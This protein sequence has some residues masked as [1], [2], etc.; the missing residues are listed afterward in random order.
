MNEDGVFE[1][2]KL[3]GLETVELAGT[4]EYEFRGKVITD[5]MPVIESNRY[6]ISCCQGYNMFIRAMMIDFG[7]P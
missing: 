2:Q 7:I 6:R 5:F 4:I 1:I 3:R